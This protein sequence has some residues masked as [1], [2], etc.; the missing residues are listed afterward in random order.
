M[1]DNG[2]DI[3]DLLPWHATGTLSRRDAQRLE[4]ALARDPELARRYELVR[5]ERAGVIDLNEALGEPSAQAMENLFARIDAEP[6]RRHSFAFSARVGDFL[7]SLSPRTLAWMAAAAACLLLVESGL[8][9][10]ILLKEGPA[11]HYETASAPRAAV[12]PGALVLIRFAPQASAADVTRFLED[13]KASVVGGPYTGGF[14]R[15]RVAP[16]GLPK[17]QLAGIIQHFEGDKV[18]SFVAATQ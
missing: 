3:E 9:G 5:E 7:A 8:L 2:K 17:A 15:I 12:G 14:Y 4:A 13:N 16:A 10:G 11:V 18:V 6:A 1:N